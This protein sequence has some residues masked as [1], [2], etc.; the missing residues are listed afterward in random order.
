MNLIMR[1]FIINAIRLQEHIIDFE[2]D[3]IE[4]IDFYQVSKKRYKEM[5][6]ELAE[7]VQ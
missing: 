7:E 1:N 2:M 4:F 3:D 6:T 5:L